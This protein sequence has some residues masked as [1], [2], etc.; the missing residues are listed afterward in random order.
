MN[1]GLRVKSNPYSLIPLKSLIYNAE[2]TNNIAK[3]EII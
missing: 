3:T 2:I 1:F